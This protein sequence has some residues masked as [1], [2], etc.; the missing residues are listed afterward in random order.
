MGDLT[1]V[2]TREGFMYL[3][4][5]TDK[6]S[7]KIV[8]YHCGDTLEAVGCS[9]ALEMALRSLPAGSNRYTIP[10]AGRSVALMNM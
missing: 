4:L 3:A 8:G 1:Y 5:L 9:Q 6:H 2:R 10:I 7:R